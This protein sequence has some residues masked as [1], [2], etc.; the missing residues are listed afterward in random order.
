MSCADGAIHYIILEHAYV[1]HVVDFYTEVF[2]ATTVY[3]YHDQ[4]SVQ[5][6]IYD[7]YVLVTPATLSNS[8]VIKLLTDLNSLRMIRQDARFTDMVLENPVEKQRST[9]KMRDP[10]GISW[11]LTKYKKEY[12]DVYRH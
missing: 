4:G 2:Q 12:S 10:Y 9:V 5:L 8:L 6:K 1:T 7:S 11:L 3:N